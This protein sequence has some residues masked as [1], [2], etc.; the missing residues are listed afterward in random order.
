MVVLFSVT[1]F[2]ETNQKRIRACHSSGRYQQLQCRIAS[3]GSINPTVL[4]A[5]AGA[6][7]IP[8]PTMATVPYSF[9]G[10][11]FYLIYFLEV[12]YQIPFDTDG[13]GDIM[14]CFSLSP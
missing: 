14:S 8:S 2:T 9:K 11:L 7:F 5:S 10:P 13:I 6:S 3:R 12:S 1:F 4:N